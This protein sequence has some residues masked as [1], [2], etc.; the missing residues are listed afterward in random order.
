MLNL[1]YMKIR[2][3]AVAL[4]SLAVITSSLAVENIDSWTPEDALLYSPFNEGEQWHNTPEA[5]SLDS[6]T[7]STLGTSYRTYRARQVESN[8]KAAN[9]VEEIDA[10]IEADGAWDHYGDKCVPAA[11]SVLEPETTA[12]ERTTEVSL[13][14]ADGLVD[15]TG[16]A[17]RKCL[18]V[19]EN[20]VDDWQFFYDDIAGFTYEAG[21]QYHLRLRRIEVDNPPADSSAFSWELIEIVSQLETRVPVELQPFTKKKL[22]VT[23]QHSASTSLSDSTFNQGELNGELHR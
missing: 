19:R 5:F 8:E 18:L 11:G 23:P 2:F 12:G 13:H 14:I 20:I 10:C 16:V 7:G 17:P 1:K 15:C 21:Y 4:L 22:S 3:L 6:V 9:Y